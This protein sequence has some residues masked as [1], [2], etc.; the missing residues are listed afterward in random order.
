MCFS[1][2][3]EH[4]DK[5][6]AGETRIKA[7]NYAVRLRTEGGL[8]AKYKRRFPAF[9]EGML[10]IIGV[11]DF[12]W[13]YFHVGNMESHTDGCVLVGYGAD[14]K[15]MTVQASV[16]A[17]TAFYKRVVGAAKDGSLRVQIIDGD[18]P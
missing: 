6:V 16:D 5:K 7:G 10:H 3:D 11:P 9:H 2:E 15:R 14:L 12:E 1:L 8:H 13:I 18:R 4:R 17:Y